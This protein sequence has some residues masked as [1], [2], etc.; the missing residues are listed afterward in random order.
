MLGWVLKLEGG[1]ET[2]SDFIEGLIRAEVE[3]RYAPLAGRVE[4]I[5]AA[6]ARPTTATA[7]GG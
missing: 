2:A 1:D 7:A 3:R 5:K 4:T 6:L